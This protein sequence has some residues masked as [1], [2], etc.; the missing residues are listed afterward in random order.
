MANRILG[1]MATGAAC[2]TEDGTAAAPARVMAVPVVDARK[3][4][5]E[6][7][8]VVEF[9]DRTVTSLSLDGNRQ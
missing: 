6:R 7:G 2:R 5:R 1:A 9:M 8:R 4:R 3:P